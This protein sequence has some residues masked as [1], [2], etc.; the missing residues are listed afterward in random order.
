MRAKEPVSMWG[1]FGVDVSEHRQVVKLFI[2]DVDEALVQFEESVAVLERDGVTLSLLDRLAR[3]THSIKGSA[4]ALGFA[5]VAEFAHHVESY[6]KSLRKHEQLPRSEVCKPLLA[7]KAFI[8]EHIQSLRDNKKSPTGG[9]LIVRSME[10]VLEP[11]AFSQVITLPRAPIAG[12]IWLM[13]DSFELELFEMPAP[14]PDEDEAPQLH[15]ND[16]EQFAIHSE[17]LRLTQLAAAVNLNTVLAAQSLAIHEAS[18]TVAAEWSLAGIHAQPAE[19][20]KNDFESEIFASVEADLPADSIAADS[21]DSIAADSVDSH[22]PLHADPAH[23]SE[24]KDIQIED[25]LNQPSNGNTDENHVGIEDRSVPLKNECDEVNQTKTLLQADHLTNEDTVTHPSGESSS[26]QV[27]L[28]DIDELLGLTE[29][30]VTLQNILD[31][32]KPVFETPLLQ[33][34]ISKLSKLI[35]QTQELSMSMKMV[36]FSSLTDTIA[37]HAQRQSILFHKAITPEIVGGNTEIDKS[38]LDSVVKPISLLISNAIEHGIEP[39]EERIEKGKPATGQIAVSLRMTPKEIIFEVSDDGRGL[40]IPQIRKKAIS[41][42]LMARLDRVSEEQIRSFIFHPG[43]TTRTSA[44]ED[45]ENQGFGLHQISYFVQRNKGRIEIDSIRDHGTVFRIVLPQSVSVIEAIVVR[46][47]SER[48][49]VPK[50]QITESVSSHEAQVDLIQGQHQLLNL[51]GTSVPL[52]QLS[53]ILRR[54][55]ASLKPDTHFQGVAL[56][57]HETNA[58][59]FAVI[60]DDVVCQKKVVIKPLGHELQGLKG[61]TGAAI[62]GD[63]KPSIILDLQELIASY[64]SGRASKLDKKSA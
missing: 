14:V 11:Q 52:I 30:L 29:E 63:G 47:G 5:E 23:E 45:E 55:S 34:T 57:A 16:P 31:E 60:V 59:P 33:K 8:R 43:F 61:L 37:T 53:T 18:P 48:F 9:E 24:L 62:L 3:T 22:S 56:I 44:N 6:V 2:Q 21:V 41:C 15:P 40:D 20:S 4:A 36:R 38:I 12:D 32:H 39:A 13:N 25:A 46:V 19:E 26:I 10:K 42:G 51:R 49:V 17:I 54:P 64:R 27:S 35:T 58:R 28:K 50:D 1:S 7:A